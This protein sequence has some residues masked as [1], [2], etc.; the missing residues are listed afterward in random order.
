M[1]GR[2]TARTVVCIALLVVLGFSLGFS[3]F[4]VIGIEPELAEAFDVPLSRVGELISLFSVAYAVLTPVLA[5][6]TGRFRRYTLLTVY[7]AAFCVANVMMALA[8][9]FEILLAARVLLG[10]VSGA[11][12]AVGVTFIPDLVGVR[13]M[14]MMIS[15]VYAAFS[16]AMVVATSVG[17]IVAETMDWHAV[18]VIALVLALLVSAAL[19]PA[20]PRTGTTDE[21]ATVRE[22][23]GLLAEPQI[24]AGIL[25]FLFG[26][27]SVYVFYGYVT[28]YLEDVLGM[29]AVGASAALMVYGVMCFVSN[30]ISGWVDLKYGMKGLLVVF[31]IQAALLAA[32]FLVGGAMPLALAPVMLIGLSMYVVSVSC[33][34]LFMRVA[35]ER[36]P[37]A[38]VLASSLE[39]MAFNMGIAFGTAVGGAVVAGTGLPYVGLVGAAF[40]LVACGC[41]GATLAIDRRRG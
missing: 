25:V 28:P 4:A 40:S 9:T 24:I 16:V 30:L 11:L 12:L 26:V 41:V 39:P 34:S 33:I 14:S 20:M 38:M 27:G 29:D 35:R 1:A 19:L 10:A 32:L 8:P 17:K 22:Q 37:K 3:E 21:P 6:T 36:H 13:R 15:V 18:M 31:P 5:V 23:V 7:L 2:R